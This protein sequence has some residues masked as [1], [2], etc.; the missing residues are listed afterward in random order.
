MQD[1]EWTKSFRESDH[2]WI[3]LWIDFAAE[4]ISNER[5][6][7]NNI[8]FWNACFKFAQTSAARE[9]QFWA[10]LCFSR[11]LKMMVL[12]VSNHA[13]IDELYFLHFH[14][15]RIPSKNISQ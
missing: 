14:D 2:F 13:N 7:I 15:V 3:D 11:K 4:I 5:R 9:L 1:Q 10:I 8:H 12:E 6:L